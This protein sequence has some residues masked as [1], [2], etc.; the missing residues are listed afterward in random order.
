MN[1]KVTAYIISTAKSGQISLSDAAQLATLSATS[2]QD[3][4][5]FS[6]Q[7]QT[8]LREAFRSGTRWC[9]ISLIPWGGV[10][11][12]MTLFLKNIEDTNKSPHGEELPMVPLEDKR[13]AS[14]VELGNARR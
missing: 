3:V 1:S 6:P 5:S 11:F 13:R 12:I 10:S 9:F 8:V 2:V 14:E 7:V 4:S